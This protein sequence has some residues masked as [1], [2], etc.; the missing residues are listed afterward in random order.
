MMF[1]G[2]LVTPLRSLPRFSIFVRCKQTFDLTHVPVLVE[3]E[4]KEKFARGS[5]P[6]G[7]CVNKTSNA[8]ILKHL[9]TGLFVKVHQT[10][11][12]EKNRQIART[13]LIDKLDQELNGEMSVAAQKERLQ[14]KRSRATEQKTQRRN[15]MKQLWKDREGIE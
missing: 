6:G 14:E 11:S 13:L 10:R 15:I 5:G 12:L 2:K 7:Q 3:E 4:L 8:V 9:P 1:V